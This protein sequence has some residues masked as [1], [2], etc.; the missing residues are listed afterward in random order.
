MI[1]SLQV[2]DLT[3]LDLTALGKSL[4]VLGLAFFVSGL[5]F[6][7]PRRRERGLAEPSLAEK[8]ERADH[9]LDQMRRDPSDRE[10][11]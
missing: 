1:S 7:L 5:V 2:P 10:L 8:V 3:M 6:F 4:I 9:H 11:G